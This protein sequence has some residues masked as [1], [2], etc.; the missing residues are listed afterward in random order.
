[1]KRLATVVLLILSACLPRSGNT[2]TSEVYSALL[3]SKYLSSS[4]DP[5][6]PTLDR[7]EPLP[8]RAESEFNTDFSK[9][10][11]PYSEILSSGPPKDGILT[12]DAPL[13]VS[14]SEADAWLKPAE[15]VIL[16]QIANDM[17]GTCR[18]SSRFARCATRPSGSSAL[19]KEKYLILVRPAARATAT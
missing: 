4:G 16:I 12:L 3:P 15:P 5:M 13:F 11:L 19:C 17:V 9:H 6:T 1:M 7:N 8:A 18:W 2:P 10:S 14:V